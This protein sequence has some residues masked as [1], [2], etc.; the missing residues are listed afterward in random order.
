MEKD[1]AVGKRILITTSAQPMRPF[2]PKSVGKI[3]ILPPSASCLIARVGLRNAVPV[4]PLHRLWLTALLAFALFSPASADV[5]FGNGIKIGEV[6]A[7]SA[8]V[9]TR[10]TTT[11]ERRADGTPFK[12]DDQKV[13]D[14]HTL[15]QMKDSLMGAAGSVRLRYKTG[16]GGEAT[17]PW[18]DAD[19]GRD[20]TAQIPLTGLHPA[21]TYTLVAEGRATGQESPNTTWEG[22]FRTAPLSDDPSPVRFVAVTCHDFP[23]RDDGDNGH[24]IYKA[25]TKLDPMFFVHTGDIEYYDKPGPWAM[26]AELARYKWNRLFSLANQRD[27]HRKFPS[28]FMK[29]DHDTLKNDCWPGQKYGELTWEQGLAIFREQVP[30]GKST[31]RTFRWGKDLQI[32]MVEGRDFRSPNNLPDG[33][34]KSILGAEQKKWL[35]ETMRGSDATFRIVLSPTPIVGPDRGSKN[36]NLAN[37]GFTHEGDEVR[38]FLASLPGTHTICGDRHWQYVSRDA[39]TGLQEFSCGP[40]SD[41]H[42]EGFSMAKRTEEHRFLRI[43]GGFLF[44]E[45]NRSSGQPRITFRHHDVLGQVVHEEISTR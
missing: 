30:M 15:A 25:M 24:L 5:H 17:S 40:G 20:F 23:R 36:D 6:D 1:A 34:E 11:A 18:Q 4:R 26:S 31:H 39:A 7:T 38:A 19:P 32:W 27:F 3:S 29:D 28:Y 21:T 12:D 14:G 9:W 35:F 2:P 10:L 8:I 22:T 13:P 33:P 45:V 43:K 41:S 42:A 16:D 37:K 44:V